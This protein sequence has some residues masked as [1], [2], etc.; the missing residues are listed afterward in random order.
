[1][2]PLIGVT[3][4]SLSHKNAPDALYRAVREAYLN[5]IEQAGGIGVVV[6]NTEDTAVLK[7]LSQRLDGLLLSG[8]G[9]VDPSYYNSSKHSETGNYGDNH[10][11]SL[12]DTTEFELLKLMIGQG[13][14]V[15]GICRGLQVVNVHF[16]GTLNQHLDDM[17]THFVLDENGGFGAIAHEVRLNRDSRLAQALDSESISVNSLHH[18]KIMEL[19]AGLLAVGVADDGTIEVIEHDWL[20]ILAVQCHPEQLM[21]QWGHSTIAELLIQLSL[22]DN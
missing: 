4:G 20:P 16:G 7:A 11:D 13:K 6:N 12:R 19:G 8:G 17:D 22:E 3:G 1:M 14:P 10:I 2:K 18:Q 15:L 5:F 21:G 9:G